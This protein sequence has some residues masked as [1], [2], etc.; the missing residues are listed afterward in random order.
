MISKL[1]SIIEK[2]KNKDLSIDPIRIKL[3]SDTNEFE[4]LPAVGPGGVG[5][6]PLDPPGPVS[7]YL[8]HTNCEYRAG[9]FLTRKAILRETIIKLHELFES[10]LKGRQWNRKKAIEQ[11]EEQDSSAVSPNQ[12]TPE[13]SKG[14]CYVFGFQYAQVDEIHKK[15]SWYPS[16]I[17]TWTKEKPIYLVSLGCRS[18]YVKDN[19]EEARSYFS[20]WLSDLS[21]NLFL[22]AL[23]GTESQIDLGYKCEWPLAEGTLV[24]LKSQLNTYQLSVPAKAKKEMYQIVIGKAQA[25]KHIYNL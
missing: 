24:E 13:L 23:S 6:V 2:N 8:W 11:L 3:I 15:I 17:R 25:L 9:S 20:K 12:H 18:I 1:I 21:K 10:E 5:V 4:P 16:D 19:K 7:L 22:P 14:I